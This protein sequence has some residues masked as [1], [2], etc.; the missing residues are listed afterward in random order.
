MITFPNSYPLIVLYE[1]IL[2]PL[3]FTNSV[4]KLRKNKNFS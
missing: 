4:D 3:L 2:S 1:E